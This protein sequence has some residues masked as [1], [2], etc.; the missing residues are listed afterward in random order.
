MA[1]GAIPV[2]VVDRRS[3]HDVRPEDLAGVVQAHFCAG[4]GGWPI[5]LRSRG[6][7]DDRP[8]WTA[9]LPCQGISRA[10]RRLG[11]ADP[12]HL[13][14]EFE[15]LVAACRPPVILGEQSGDGAD[16]IRLVRG[17]LDSLEYAMGTVPFTASCAGSLHDRPRYYFVADA[18]D[19]RRRIEQREQ[20]RSPEGPR[21]EPYR[22]GEGFALG[23]AQGDEDGRP[24]FSHG[25]GSEPDQGSGADGLE[26]VVD[27]FGKARLAPSGI[28]RLVDGIRGRVS[29]LRA[30]GEEE[31]YSRVAA[32]RGLGNALDQRAA[33]A[34]VSA[35]MRILVPLMGWGA[36]AMVLAAAAIAFG[37]SGSQLG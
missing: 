37:S 27:R 3:I 34:F 36:M 11:F 8:V 30:D 16:W 13:W 22:R 31:T 21:Y 23:H 26:W 15:R 7:R 35:C 17:R 9:S 10:G 29:R 6:W 5:A 33:T 14:P 19:E 32:L 24:G 20:K 28:R 2:G 12:R 25:A 18:D 4:I 1:A